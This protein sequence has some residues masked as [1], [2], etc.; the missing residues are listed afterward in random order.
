MTTGKELWGESTKEP[1]T[2]S[3]KR[4]RVVVLCKA[5]GIEYDIRE[6]LNERNHRGAC[7]V[8]LFDCPKGHHC[9]ARRVFK[10]M[11]Q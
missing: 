11:V 7:H 10:E 1:I 5:C 9:E 2:I 3:G 4:G 8:A 6:V